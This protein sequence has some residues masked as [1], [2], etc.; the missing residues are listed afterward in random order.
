MQNSSRLV[1]LM[2]GMLL[3]GYFYDENDYI[4]PLF[5]GGKDKFIL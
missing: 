5:Y 4:S 3:L 1:L 2:I